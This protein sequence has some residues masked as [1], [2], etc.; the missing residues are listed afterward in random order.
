MAEEGVTPRCRFG[1]PA[2]YAIVEA[3]TCFTGGTVLMDLQPYVA[4]STTDAYVFTGM[5]PATAG[6][7]SAKYSL[8]YCEDKAYSSTAA[9][10]FSEPVNS[11][12]LGAAASDL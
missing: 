4:A 6:G 10:K 12:N 2:N 7:S 5:V 3:E 8:C 11:T 1:T 9:T